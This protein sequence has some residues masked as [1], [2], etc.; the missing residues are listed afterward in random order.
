MSLPLL[1]LPL[2]LLHAASVSPATVPA[3]GAQEAILTLDRAGRYIVKAHSPAGTACEIVD[4]VRGPFEQSGRVG[5][6]SC[7]LDL[8][9]DAG[10]Y[11]LRLTSKSKG[12]GSVALSVTPY[13]ELN[14]S[15]VRLEPRREVKQSLKPRQQASYWLKIDKRQAVTLRLAGRHAGDVRLWRSGEWLEPLTARDTSPRPHPGQPIHEWWFEAML[16]PGVY[17]LTAYGTASTTWTQSE[18]PDDAGLTVTWGFPTAPEERIATLTLPDTGL[19]TLEFPSEPEA[20]FLSREGNSKTAT[21]LSLHAMGDDGSTNV[22]SSAE[23]SCEIDGKAIVPEC[24]AFSDAKHRR[25]ALIRG[26]PGAHV[27][28]RWARLYDGRWE[29]GVYGN[30]AQSL[31]FG[32]PKE[33]DYLVTIHET[34]LDQDHAPVGCALNAVLSSGDTLV[35]RRD[36]LQVSPD[37]PFRRSF[38]YSG[39]G[40]TL[41]FEITRSARYVF[42]TAGDRKTRCELFRYEGDKLTRLTETQPEAKT[43][44]VAIPATPGL[45]ELRLYGGTEGIENV[46]VAADG[47]QPQGETPTKVSCIFPK[48]HLGTYSAYALT[49][50]RSSEKALRGLFLRSLPLTLG[51]P[52]ALVLDGRK[53]VKLPLSGGRPVE[54]RALSG[55]A[56]NCALGDTK[57]ATKG[58]TCSLPGSAGELTLENPGDAAITLS[59]RRPS[60]P[61]PA[62]PPLVAFSPKLAPLPVLAPSTP[63]W[64]DFDRGENH[65]LIFDVKDAGLYHVTTQG[66]L[67][68]QC[69]I[70]TPVVQEVGAATG[71]GRGRNCLVSSYLRP[72]RYLLDVRTVGKSRGRGAVLLEQRAVKPAEGVSGD[73]E[74]FFRADAG[75]LIQQ[76]LRV[77]K[78]GEYTLSTAAQSGA[79]QCRLDDPQGWPV[80]RIPAPCT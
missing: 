6:S 31:S 77:P 26:E 4:H 27:T 33:G 59:V 37:S 2:L 67:S 14:P 34:P 44:R 57:V 8:L 16:E 50:T 18:T 51:E 53:S 55:E 70:R 69:S 74:V 38:N 10:T 48:V 56:F 15:P 7:E 63:M 32:V 65:S 17:L 80:V 49:S 35:Q 52:L 78:R 21:R 13:T 12:K 47:P 20:V 40:A 45:Y 41:Q 58:G 54:I 68:T 25:V 72:G 62:P 61:P 75:D 79:L 30:G 76:K 71:G 5:R 29:D 1:T 39:G 73:A 22:F 11:K 3:K 46:T 24:K 28:L 42:Q 66:L 19:A 23:G 9:L 36:L 43:C 64:L 60:P